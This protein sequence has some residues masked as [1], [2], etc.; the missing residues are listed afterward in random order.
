MCI[1]P[2]RSLN[3]HKPK[4]TRSDYHLMPAEQCAAYLT[5]GLAIVTTGYGGIG[6]LAD[7]FAPLSV[8]ADATRLISDRP[9]QQKQT[10]G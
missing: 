5:L 10:A 4:I 1:P 6:L 2:V 8:I 9:L 7:Q 3:P